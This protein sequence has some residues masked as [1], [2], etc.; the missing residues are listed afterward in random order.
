MVLLPPQQK[1]REKIYQL[2][3]QTGSFLLMHMVSFD[4]GQENRRPGISDWTTKVAA[5]L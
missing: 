4:A 5:I 2:D 1:H 3:Q